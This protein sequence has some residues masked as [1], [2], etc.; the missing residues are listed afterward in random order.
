MRRLFWMAILILAVSGTSLK[1]MAQETSV[2]NDRVASLDEVLMDYDEHRSMLSR[3]I[4]DRGL[5][6]AVA[7]KA[8]IGYMTWDKWIVITQQELS[9]EDEATDLRYLSYLGSTGDKEVRIAAYLNPKHIESQFEMLESAPI[10]YTS[11]KTGYVPFY[12]Y[13]VLFDAGHDVHLELSAYTMQATR[14]HYRR[15]HRLPL[16]DKQHNAI[17]DMMLLME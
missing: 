15:D 5:Q 12:Y 1:T 4:A 2:M 13:Y 7:G 8:Y 10:E 9:E 14:Q 11:F 16:S 6:D 17:W 3:I